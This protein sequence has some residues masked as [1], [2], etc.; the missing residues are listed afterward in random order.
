MAKFYTFISSFKL[1]NLPGG[2]ADF[3]KNMLTQVLT[4]QFIVFSLNNKMT[5]TEEMKRIKNDNCLHCSLY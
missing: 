4:N 5:S 1:L 2:K 3:L